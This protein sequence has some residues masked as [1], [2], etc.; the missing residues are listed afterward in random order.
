MNNN[1][2]IKTALASFG[3]SGQVFHGPFLKVNPRFEVVAICERNREL[4]MQMFPNARI[5]R[6]YRLLTEDPEI[7]AI[8]VNT[9]DYLHFQMAKEA[10]EGG[11]HV[12]VE[13]PF[14][15]KS[16]EAR[17]L[18]ALAEKKN[19]VLTVYQNRRWDGDFLTVKKI[20][21]EKIL[22]RIVEFESHFDRYKKEVADSWKEN[23][24][25]NYGALYNLGSHLADQTLA[26]FGMPS[27]VTAHLAI[28]RQ[29]G[30]IFDYF[31]IRLKYSSFSALLKCSY[32]V[33]NAFTRFVIHGENGSFAKSGL[34][35]QEA[36]LKKGELPVG[37]SWGAD[38]SELWGQLSAQIN[39]LPFDGKIETI[40][41]NYTAF[42]DNFY[43]T[44]REGA[45]LSV[46]PE[47]ALNV[48]RLLELCI[49]SHNQGKTLP[50]D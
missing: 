41:G 10:L 1:K 31:D 46:K 22:G 20:I 11:K 49:E 36:R 38:E 25:G 18:I 29:G 37:N 47:E 4:S 35:P 50:T 6:D 3:M 48:I 30:K 33:Y 23:P 45:P 8:I 40:K 12:I 34:D 21:D 32:L 7:E 17:E 13:K 9:P 24:T 44:V 39:G 2:K 42:Y 43:E 14:T 19:L 16:N 26:L 28:A 15:L 27:A 5:V